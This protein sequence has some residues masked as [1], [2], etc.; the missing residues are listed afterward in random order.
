MEPNTQKCLSG[1]IKRN[2]LVK[3]EYEITPAEGQQIH[4][5]VSIF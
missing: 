1:D 5:V 3:G 4:Y 2:V